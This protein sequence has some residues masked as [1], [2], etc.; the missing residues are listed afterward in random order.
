MRMVGLLEEKG[1][2]K[3]EGDIVE[4]GL[5]FPDEAYQHQKDCN[6]LQ[7]DP[8]NAAKQLGSC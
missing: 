2:S 5:P 6:V 8:G 4:S 3:K 7:Q 1:R